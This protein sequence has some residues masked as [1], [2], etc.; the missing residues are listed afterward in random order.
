[1]EAGKKRTQNPDKLISVLF[2]ISAAVNNTTCRDEFYRKIHKIMGTVL[3][4]EN[5]AIAIFHKGKDIISLPYFKDRQANAQDRYCET[6]DLAARV[7]HQKQILRIPCDE[8]L[9]S[10]TA[11]TSG[12]P[13]VCVGVPLK[14]KNRTFG[15]LILKS[16]TSTKAYGDTALDILNSISGFVAM[17]I[18]RKLADEGARQNEKIT[19][20]LFSISNAV[21][22]TENLNELYTS[23]HHTLEDVVDVSNFAI[24]IYDRQTD[25]L[26]YPYYVDQTGDVY[27]E[28]KTV[29]R[30]GIIADDVIRLKRPVFL[31]KME[32][33]E[34]SKIL[35][36]DVVGSIP[37]Q[38][39]GV[40]L[41]IQK[42]VVGVIAV[43]HYSNPD[44]YTQKDKNLLVAVSD[45]I[46]LAINRKRFQ[47][48]IIQSEKLTQT[49]FYISNAVNTTDNLDDLYGSIYQS[50]NNLIPLP[51][52]Y[53][54]LVD[55]DSKIMHFPFYL[56]EEDSED[57][58]SL[59]VDYSKNDNYITLDA[60]RSKKPLFMTEKILTQKAEKGQLDGTVPRIWIGVPLMIRETVTGVMAVQHYTDPDYFTQRDM[61]LLVAVSDQVAL[62]VDRKRAQETIL[63]RERQI[64]NLSRQTEKFSL[65]AAAIITMQDEKEIFHRISRAI[66]ENSDYNRLLISYFTE[67]PPYREILG[68]EGVSPEEIEKVKNKPALREYYGTLFDAG[69]KIGNFAIY[70][71]HTQTDVPGS[72][73]LIISKR[74][75]QSPSD[76]WHPGDMLFFPMHDSDGCLIGV[77]SADESKSGKKPTRETVRP[78]EIFSSLISQIIIVKKIQ[79][80]LKDHKENLEKRVADRTEDLTAEI[81]ERIEVEKMLK[82]AKLQAEAGAQAK[83][84]FLTNMSHEIRTP[85]NGI[86]GMAELALEYNLEDDLKEILTTI[87]AETTH[88]LGLINQILDFSKIEAGKF[89][90]ENIAFNLEHTFEQTCSALGVGANDKGLEFFSF[91]S[92]RI[93]TRLVGDPGRLRQVLVNLTSNAIKFTPKG[94]VLIKVELVRDMGH[95][96]ELRFCVKDTGIGIAKEKQQTIFE[97]FN[98]ADGSTTRKYGGTGLGTTI[99]KQLVHLMGG[100]IGLESLEGKGSTFWFTTQFKK[101]KN[102]P[103]AVTIPGAQPKAMTILVVDDNQTSQMILHQYLTHFGSVTCLTKNTEEAAKALAQTGESDRKVDVAIVS[104]GLLGMNGFDAVKTIREIDPLL[105]VVFVTSKGRPGDTDTC[106][107][108]GINEYLLKPIKRRDFE[109]ALLSATGRAEKPAQETRE[110]APRPAIAENLINTEHILVAEDYPTN[111]KI[112]MKYLSAAGFKVS[113]AENGSQA[114]DLFKEKQ[115][116]LILMDI[117]MPEMDGCEATGLIRSLEGKMAGP[118]DA[119]YSKIPIIAMTAH[120]IKGYREKC[121]AAGMD[122]YM[123]KPLRKAQVLEMVGKWIDNKPLGNSDAM[124]E[125][126]EQN[127]DPDI[128]D[129]Q[130]ALDEFEGDDEFLRE[131]LDEFFEILVTQLTEIKTALEENDTSTIARHAH[132]IKGGAANLTADRLS[133]IAHDL[134]LMGKSGSIDGG[135]RIFEQL[136]KEIKRLKNRV[137]ALAI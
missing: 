54:C 46:A 76:T 50:L 92:P 40:P 132:A 32:T 26:S 14:V 60:I 90:I 33:I 38:W 130:K 113:L 29:S 10:A 137:A 85:L 48:E 67:A 44:Y 56:D 66:V 115:F 5:F 117:Q 119:A 36:L 84:K 61:E 94:E 78:L 110:P 118:G 53:I 4:V 12:S 8:S 21:N 89:S 42:E 2:D 55:E 95:T 82:K 52:F 70:L 24:G 68:Y 35:G 79:K 43:Q 124:S 80:E 105:P 19:Q 122:D 127:R 101:Q 30:S 135:D 116:D 71:P 63:K 34:R 65:A 23:I 18:E 91:L 7:I 45:Q 59:S 31:S 39:L 104:Q 100:R 128:F 77:I 88:L 136:E 111:Q 58:L 109:N 51:N 28:I 1:M 98:Q 114:V 73:L 133:Q 134:E 11:K 75:P 47:D 97:S 3:D 57:T 9:R 81:R 6:T 64:L 99:S 121:L 102:I 87:D 74:Q 25:T 37:E 16:Y 49:L 22:T 83:I 20:T 129:A 93:P 126:S 15:A 112:I 69:I 62:A 13:R 107:K 120:A 123:T 72:E 108:M 131:V 41:K 27:R 96:A 86:M 106:K 17:A 103:N 125:R